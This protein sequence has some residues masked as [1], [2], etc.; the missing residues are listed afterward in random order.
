LEKQK[1]SEVLL[2]ITGA[3]IGLE[4][5]KANCKAIIDSALEECEFTPDQVKALMAVSSQG[6]TEGR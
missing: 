2:A 1:V 4:D 3:L 5:A 6:A